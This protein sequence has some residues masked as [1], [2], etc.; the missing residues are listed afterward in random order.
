MFCRSVIDRTNSAQS[1]MNHE[2]SRSVR[3]SL[4]SLTHLEGTV[5]MGYDMIEQ[6]EIENI[7]ALCG[8]KL[9]TLCMC[10][11]AHISTQ[12]AVPHSR[13]HVACSK[14]FPSS[15]AMLW[16]GVALALCSVSIHVPVFSL[17]K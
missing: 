15:L 10:I 2:S 6:T 9:Q 17:T 3:K 1:I 4:S 14:T 12:E 16:C 13:V 8:C 5:V 11:L 7:K